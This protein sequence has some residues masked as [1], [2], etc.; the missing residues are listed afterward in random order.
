MLLK[1]KYEKFIVNLSLS[2]S[3]EV[4]LKTENSP[5][6]FESGILGGSCQG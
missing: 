6:A 3:G 5:S 2:R 1:A 4:R